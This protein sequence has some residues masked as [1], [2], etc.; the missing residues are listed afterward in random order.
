[1]ASDVSTAAGMLTVEEGGALLELARQAIAR[2]LDRAVDVP[3]NV[4]QTLAAPRLQERRGVFVTL[5]SNGRLRGCIGSLQPVGSIVEGVQD[6]A[7]KAAF[8]DP[9]FPGLSVEEL[10][11][12]Q[13]EVSVLTPLSP[14]SYHGSD[15]LVARLRP[16]RAGVLIEQGGLSATFLPQVWEQLPQPEHF[17][18]Q[19]CLKAGLP[20]AAWREGR[21]RV[22]TYQVQSFV[23]Q[24]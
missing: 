7:L 9:R 15:D 8:G 16:G 24:R 14:L 5:K 22:E 23:E 13:I 3:A 18:G 21:L 2:R 12:V 17:L 1:M 19:L 10:P 4:A 11:A 6:N 20:A